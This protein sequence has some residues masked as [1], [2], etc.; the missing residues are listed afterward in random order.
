MFVDA[1]HLLRLYSID[2]IY[3]NWL[4]GL[5]RKVGYPTALLLEG[6]GWWHIGTGLGAYMVI[7]AS[8]RLVMSVKEESADNFAFKYFL[9]I[10]PFVVRTKPFKPGKSRNSVAANGKADKS[11]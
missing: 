7:A 11:R 6:H 8:Q 3:C 1:D 2:N 10:H 9:G 5:R 4:R